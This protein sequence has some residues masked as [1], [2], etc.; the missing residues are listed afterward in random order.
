MAAK[1]TTDDE[2]R[3]AAFFANHPRLMGVAFLLIHLIAMTGQA[4][5]TG[6]PSV[7]GP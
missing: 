6:T 7:S 2:T 5:A 1:D 3:L 4:V